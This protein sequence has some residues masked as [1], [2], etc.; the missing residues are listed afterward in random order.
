MVL[1]QLLHFIGDRPLSEFSP[2]CNE[3]RGLR[4]LEQRHLDTYRARLRRHL[5]VKYDRPLDAR[6]T[7]VSLYTRLDIVNAALNW[8]H[9][10]GYLNSRPSVKRSQPPE[11]APVWFRPGQ[12]SR[13]FQLAAAHGRP[14]G[15]VLEFAKLC[16][17][18]GLRPGEALSL[19]WSAVDFETG[20]LT[21]RTSGRRDRTKS[22]RERILPLTTELREHLLSLPHGGEKDRVLRIPYITVRRFFERVRRELGIEGS[23][24]K[25]R[26]SFATHLLQTGAADLRE[27][28]YLLGHAKLTTTQKYTHVDQDA[29]RR[30]L[31]A[32]QLLP[33]QLEVIPLRRSALA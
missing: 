10:R 20:T 18:A 2:A 33:S 30:K 32:V 16:Y 22:D 1:K 5:A 19:R 21:I 11:A 29:L 13:V 8:A 28:Q 27:V 7:E 26:H 9:S 25:L 12:L 31:D 24:H 14:P 4:G 23:A 6:K 3:A 17:L 15:R